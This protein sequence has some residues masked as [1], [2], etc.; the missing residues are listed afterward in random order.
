M[1]ALYL[2]SNASA[3]STQPLSIFAAAVN[4]N[5]K[6]SPR[7]SLNDFVKTARY[8]TIATVLRQC[9][10][11]MLVRASTATMALAINSDINGCHGSDHCRIMTR[12][13]VRA[14]KATATCHQCRKFGHWI[15]EHAP[16]D[17][18]P[19]TVSSSPTPLDPASKQLSERRKM[20][21]LRS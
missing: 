7:S 18:L 5:S 4:N 11:K 15:S 21:P 20:F 10:E 12:D 14:A 19:S 17:S 16:D 8:K 2:L 1:T 6:L 13:E 9:Y 3:G